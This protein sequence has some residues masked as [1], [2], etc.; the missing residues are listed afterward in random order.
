MMQ[1][2]GQRQ[3]ITRFQFQ[4]SSTPSG[5]RFKAFLPLLVPST[6]QAASRA[7]RASTS[8]TVH[9]PVA[10]SPQRVV[11]KHRRQRPPMAS[12]RHALPLLLLFLLAAVVAAAAGE[13]TTALHARMAAEWAWSAA[14]ASDDDSCWGSPEE[15]PVVFDVDAEGGAGVV[16]A[17]ARARLRLQEAAYYDVNTAADLLPTAQHISYGALIRDSVP[18]SI[19]G[20]SYYNCQPGAEANSYTRGCSEIA[21]CRG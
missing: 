4:A 11:S 19:P 5:L 10:G 6:A 3:C 15:C 16:G 17:A 9:R 20:A 1:E 7:S 14:G 12:S 8:C 21:Q 2:Q 13:L 18:C